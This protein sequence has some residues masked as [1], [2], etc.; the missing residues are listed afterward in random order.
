MKN[1]KQLLIII[2]ITL[3]LMSK[4]QITTSTLS[5]AQYVTNVLLGPGV[6][7]SGITYTGLPRMIASFTAPTSTNLGLKKGVYLTC[8]SNGTIAGELGPAGPSSL[9]QSVDQNQPGDASL[10]ALSGIGTNDAAVLEFDF[11]P[12]S[13]TVKFRYV[14]GSEEYNDYVNSINDAFAFILSGV[15]TP[16]AATN[17]ALVPGTTIPITINTVNNGNSMGVSTGP[18]VNCAYYR[19]NISG[20]IDCV[21]DGL[22]TVLTAKH[23]VICG[24]TY[25]IKIAIADASDNVFDSG[26][27][28]EAGSFSSAPP[29]S[30]SSSNS[31]ASFTDS[32]M[33][34]DCNSNCVYFIR[35]SNT[36]QK[37]SFKLQVSGNAILNSDYIQIGNPSFTW[38]TQL[39]FAIGQDTLKI[40][41]LKALQ[42][43]ITETTDTIVFTLTSY[44]TSLSSCAISTSVK[45]KFYIND[46]KPIV[47]GAKDTIVCNGASTILNANA[48][49][50][51]STYTFTW[52][53]PPTFTSNFNIG[54]ITSPSTYT[55]QVNDICNKFI[56]KV[57]NVTPSTLP[58][59]SANPFNSFCLDSIKKI[60]L[61]ITGGKPNYTINWSIPPTGITPYDT[62]S[63]TYYF[64]QT[65]IPSSNTYSISVTDQCNN[66]NTISIIIDAIDCNITIPNVVTANGD[67]VN[68][69]FKINGILNF[70]GSSLMV[71]NRWGH[72]IYSNDD[73]KN[74]W[75][76]DETSGTYFYILNVSDGR[77]LNGFFQLFKN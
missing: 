71:F 3:S 35:T 73:Y 75:K 37:D 19:D 72:K 44:T 17:I 2:A 28:L 26:V 58:L 11:I 67:N 60:T 69:Y 41:N 29:I 8:G 31:N 18:C 7:A 16:L 63:T 64:T 76:P 13:D 30:V 42:D 14:F 32:V 4:G 61:N 9:F 74:D 65:L 33:V 48:S 5:V 24:E 1:I 15:S 77:K 23:K 27:F 36:A 25:H 12:Q 22:T 34:E 57:I 62:N 10:T 46:Y 56:T 38:P 70:P 66:T 40:C 6:T 45:F 20:T 47:I 43:N 53:N 51:F 49:F 68:D 39:N 54:V 21:Y 50:G 52:T 55:I 59:L